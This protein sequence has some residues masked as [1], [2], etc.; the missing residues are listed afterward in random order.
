MKKIM[1]G[2]DYVKRKS[3]RFL[4]AKSSLGDSPPLITKLPTSELV[5]ARKQSVVVGDILRSY[6]TDEIKIVQRRELFREVSR[7]YIPPLSLRTASKKLAPL[8]KPT[9]EVLLSQREHRPQIGAFIPVLNSRNF[10][11]NFKTYGRPRPNHK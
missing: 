11:A 8:P 5:S 10:L 9:E 4:G 3:T 6:F 2:S 7:T 1:E